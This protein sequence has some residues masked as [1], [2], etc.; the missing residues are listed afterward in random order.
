MSQRRL[1]FGHHI[2][3]THTETEIREHV[4]GWLQEEECLETH[5]KST[6]SFS[7]RDFPVTLITKEI[8]NWQHM[9]VT[10]TK[11]HPAKISKNAENIFPSKATR[12]L[13]FYFL[14]LIMK[15]LAVT[16]KLQINPYV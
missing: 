1:H 5:K 11:F 2:R 12:E 4:P 7:L 15:K 14:F 3:H 13:F 10:K 8:K 9:Q 16:S 6:Y